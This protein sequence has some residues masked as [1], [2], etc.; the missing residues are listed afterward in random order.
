MVRRLPAFAGYVVD[1][2]LREFRKL[3]MGKP[4][5]FI[6][7]ASPKGREL[8]TAWRDAEKEW[9][10][11]SQRRAKGYKMTVGKARK[12][13][14]EIRSKLSDQDKLK[15]DSIMSLLE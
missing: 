6:P 14:L 3:E 1:E 8:L 4:P 13:H 5:E 2:R 7:F 10:E 15:L 12:Y 11:A 9:E